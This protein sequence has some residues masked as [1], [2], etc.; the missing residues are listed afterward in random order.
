VGQQLGQVTSEGAMAGEGSRLETE[1]DRIEKQISN[2]Q[3][4]LQQTV[5]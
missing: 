4:R 1:L 3:E 2:L 5:T